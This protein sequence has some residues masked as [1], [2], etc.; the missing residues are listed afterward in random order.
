MYIY[1]LTFD[2]YC[3]LVQ[4][5]GGIGI[6]QGRSSEWVPHWAVTYGLGIAGTVGKSKERRDRE[7]SVN[8]Q[9]TQALCGHQLLVDG[10][11]FSCPTSG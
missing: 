10:R 2:V 4:I 9:N 11:R 7:R 1:L 6:A 3:F 8:Y 5:F